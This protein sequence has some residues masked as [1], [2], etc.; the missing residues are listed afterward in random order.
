[1]SRTWRRSHLAVAGA[2]A[3]TLAMAGCSSSKKSD[4]GGGGGG[5]ANAPPVVSAGPSR[6]V[7]AGDAVPLG[8]SVSDPNGDAVTHAWTL[9]SKPA[10]SAAQ[11]AADAALDG[12]LQTDVEGAYVL[13][14]AAS[15]G[16]LEATARVTLTAAPR[17]AGGAT[18]QPGA[19]GADLA[20]LAARVDAVLSKGYN[21][22]TADAVMKRLSGKD[23]KADGTPIPADSMRVLD[24]RRAEDFAKG[25]IPGAINVP[26]PLLPAALLGNPALLGTKE[27]AVASYNG[28]DGNM[29]S[30]LVNLARIPDPSVSHPISRA[31][32]G[33]MTTWSFDRALSPT[34][35]D[36]DKGVRRVEDGAI[37][38]GV[39]AG[40]D[41]GRFPTYAAFSPGTDD[42]TRKLLVRAREYLT[43]LDAEGAWWTDF[44]QY[45]ALKG[46]ASTDDDPQVLSV[47]S[48]ADYRD[49][50]HVPGAINVPWQQ[51]AKLANAKL[52]DPARKVFVYCYTGHTGGIAT[53]ALGILGYQTRNLLYGINGWTSSSSVVGTSLRRFDVARAWDF[54]L[55][56]T[57][58]AGISTLDGWAPPAT[59]CLGC[60]AN[61]T[62]LYSAYNYAEPAA[63]GVLSE[64][65]G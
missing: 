45:R 8:A 56:D 12:T 38:T 10:G 61:L 42:V 22:I 34:R 5:G 41:Q 2:L 17:Y 63:A 24:V 6:T 23:R 62:A 64:G 26:L 28:G 20:A 40:I 32:M 43:A 55:H 57:G 54:P 47:R 46:T 44:V 51:V 11:L 4:A 35:F 18:G 48:L 7:T 49:R 29:A 3:A 59:G 60:H 19:Q 33:G 14:L 9:V 52:I 31:I 15:D 1:M 39:V 30:L 65:E 25:H 50:G 53:M 16:K 58:D 37:Q 36:D 21:T 13:D 27:V